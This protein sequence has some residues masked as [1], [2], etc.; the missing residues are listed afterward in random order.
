MN[1]RYIYEADRLKYICTSMTEP[2]WVFWE[3]CNTALRADQN[4]GH[5]YEPIQG[6]GGPK[7]C[8]RKLLHTTLKE[9]VFF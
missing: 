3:E 6:G 4:D 5:G 8:V 7:V 1:R 2:L 9:L